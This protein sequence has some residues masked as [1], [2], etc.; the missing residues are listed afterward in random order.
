MTDQPLVTTEWV[1]NHIGDP[2]LV[3]LDATFVLPGGV[4]T[5][6][7]L[8]AE[9]HL[10]GAVFF[11]IDAMADHES[12]LPHML[13]DA[14]DF[15]D[16][17]GALGCGNDS[18]VVVYDTPGLMSAGRA[19][20]TLKVFGHD[21]VAVMDGGLRKWQSEGRPL[22]A[23]VPTPDKAQFQA[24]FR[25]ELVRSREQVRAALA[26]GSA[27]VVD[28][29]SAARF[30]GDEPEARPGLRSGHMPGARNLPFGLLSNSETGEVLSPEEIKA[31]FIASGIDMHRPVIASCGSGVTAAALAFGL[32]LIGSKAAVYDG[33]WAEW[34]MP[35]DTQVA[36]GEAGPA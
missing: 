29:R 20:W 35:G 26:D 30:R 25:P 11:D 32:H 4:P 8:Y 28:A 34:G 5:A 24:R 16:M 13:P 12:R 31:A 9:R 7:E 18:F 3:V 23:T 27:Q 2:G 14:D 21:R 17:I 22:T 36:T 10:P 15:G 19:W 1:A 33:A 6:A